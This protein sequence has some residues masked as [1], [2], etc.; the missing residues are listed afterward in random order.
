MSNKDIY[1]KS[2]IYFKN[3]IPV[4]SKINTYIN[5]YERIS[6]DHIKAINET[7]GKPFI[8]EDTWRELESSTRKLIKKYIRDEE[9]ILDVGVGLGRLLSSFSNLKRY[10]IDISMDYLV[11]AKEKGIEVCFSLIEDMPYKKNFFDMVVCT[12]VLEHVIDLNLVIKKILSVLKSNGYLVIRVPY[13]ENLKP[14][15]DSSYPYAFA[16]LRNFDE[17]SLKI[18]FIKIFGCRFIELRKVTL[19]RNDRLKI[20]SKII[21]KK[22]INKIIYYTKFINYKL[23]KFLVNNFYEPIEI[24]MV[25]K[26]K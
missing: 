16:H 26:R 20:S 23:Y 14:Y 19:L 5:N 7:G 10:G 25:F 12:D 8:P 1:I 6:Y 3:G 21:I 4:F 17:Y 2:P 15:L 24:N 13:K 22:V 18:L 9:R 11:I